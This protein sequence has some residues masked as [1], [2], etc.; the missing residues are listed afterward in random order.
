MAISD[1]FGFIDYS[2]KIAFDGGYINPCNDFDKACKW[3]N[4]C[5]N[6]D[7]F[8]YPHFERRVKYDRL[9]DK[10]GRR[11]P[12]TDRPAFLH[13]IPSTHVL[14]LDV[15]AANKD[16][17]RSSDAGFIM[18]LLAYIFGTRLQFHDWCFDG[19]I[20]IE[21]THNIHFSHSVI[22][23]FISHSYKVWKTWNDK[24][25]RLFINILFMYSRTPAY[26]W[27]W[28]R[29]IGE[30][31]VFDA[32]FS[33]SEE[34]CNCKASS[35]KARFK[36]VCAKFGIQFNEPLINEIYK[37]RNGLFHHTLWSGG[38][39]CTA[40][41]NSFM[42]PYNLRRFNSRLIPALLGYKTTFIQTSWWDFDTDSFDKT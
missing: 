16:S 20:P 35:H 2:S 40:D 38:Q 6:Q 9:K 39:P 10:A 5:K 15:D 4:K 24:H 28:E 18:H 7:G 11:I 14:T 17:L 3:V 26:E 42:Q 37:L 32:A 25:R 8:L 41:N 1:R 27:D 23:D 31:M 36:A 21:P 30:Y 34:I 12:N 22:E 13:K 19:R 33:L 29:F